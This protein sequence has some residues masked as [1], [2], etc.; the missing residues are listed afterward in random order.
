MG[1]RRDDTT[2]GLR[3]K[4]RNRLFIAIER[5]EEINFPSI[6]PALEA[7]P[8]NSSDALHFLEPGSLNAIFTEDVFRSK[9]IAR[10]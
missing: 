8:R 4:N 6:S 2:H 10:I 9:I 3:A 7:V 5:S 1:K